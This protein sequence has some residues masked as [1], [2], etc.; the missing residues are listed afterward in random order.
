MVAYLREA[1]LKA[2][3]KVLFAS[4]LAV[5]LLAITETGSAQVD[6]GT[7]LG[8]QSQTETSYAPQGPGVMLGALDPAMRR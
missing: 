2:I 3:S 6:Y 5:A 4:S 1:R 8:L 7:R